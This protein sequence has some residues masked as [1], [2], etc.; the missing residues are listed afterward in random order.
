MSDE[1]FIALKNQIKEL[2]TMCR[3][4]NISFDDLKNE[5]SEL[6]KSIVN[7][8]KGIHTLNS[9]VNSLAGDLL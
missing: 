9:D 7:F 5:L 4:I 8:E 2:G 3:D 1:E 6:D